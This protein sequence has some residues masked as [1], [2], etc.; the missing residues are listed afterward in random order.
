MNSSSSEN[1]NQSSAWPPDERFRHRVIY[2]TILIAA[3]TLLV[4]AFAGAL[5]AA[6]QVVCVVFVG[7]LIGIVLANLARMMSRVVP[8]PHL[9]CL[10]IVV[11]LLIGVLAGG[12]WYFGAQVESRVESAAS[13]FD[14]VKSKIRE[15]VGQSTFLQSM[16]EATPWTQEILTQSNDQRAGSYWDQPSSVFTEDESSTSA[17]SQGKSSDESNNDSEGQPT[18]RGKTSNS[19]EL[20]QP[21][22]RAGEAK[23][24]GSSNSS[25]SGSII[26][27][28]PTSVASVIGRI[29]ASTLGLITDLYVILFIAMFV[30]AEPNT[31]RNGF[32]GLLPPRYRERAGE[33]MKELSHALWRW[34]I[35]RLGSMLVTAIL[36]SIGMALLGVPFPILLGTVTGIM[37]FV[38]NIGGAISGVLAFLFALTVGTTTALLV[39]PVYLAIQLVE[40]N[41]ITPLIQRQQIEAPPALLIGIQILMGVLFGAWGVLVASPLLAVLIVLNKTVYRQD[42]L[43]ESPED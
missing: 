29:F 6:V 23:S 34:F 14:E 2:A 18:S 9:A 32:L 39:I 1:E 26:S 30:A 25:E 16:S 19:T 42:I 11:L 3:V 37:V 41:F 10:A 35:G 36:T 4:T 20:P 15:L 5:I 38:P 13:R 28:V 17:T 22:Q 7:V 21:N 27:A 33:V 8:L 31:Y 40:S 12:V 24:G 43:G